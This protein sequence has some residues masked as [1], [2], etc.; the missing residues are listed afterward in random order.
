MLPLLLVPLALALGVAVHGAPHAATATP[1]SADSTAVSRGVE[2]AVIE[3]DN[4]AFD[5]A[6]VYLVPQ[7]GVPIRLGQVTGGG[8][9]RFVV[10]RG[11]AY[12]GTFEIVAVPFPRRFAVGSGP[13]TLL[14]GDALRASLSPSQNLVS[15][16][17]AR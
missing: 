8:N 9:S 6:T 14:A 1:Y 4:Q 16:L 17:P 10:P 12:G 15:V 13:L 2:P 7:F 3:F 5:L 11:V